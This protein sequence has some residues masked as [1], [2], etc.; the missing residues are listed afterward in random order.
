MTCNDYEAMCYTMGQSN[1]VSNNEAPPSRGLAQN[2]SAIV[3]GLLVYR[4][5][6]AN[7]VGLSGRVKRA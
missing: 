5:D 7:H 2:G 6:G 4:E 3:Y 1:G